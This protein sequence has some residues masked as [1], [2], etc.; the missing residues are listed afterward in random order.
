MTKLLSKAQAIALKSS[1][2]DSYNSEF[3]TVFFKREKF[4]GETYTVELVFNKELLGKEMPSLHFINYQ[5]NKKIDAGTNTDVVV[6][7]SKKEIFTILKSLDYD[8][9]E[10]LHLKLQN[11]LNSTND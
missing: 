6:T 3:G 11:L 4:E 1:L 7:L 5:L 10:E 9:N 2:M 8:S